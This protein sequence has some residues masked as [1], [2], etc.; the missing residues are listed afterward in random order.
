MPYLL[1][2]KRRIHGME[3]EQGACQD[4]TKDRECRSPSISSDFGLIPCVFEVRKRL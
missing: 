3:S 4:C 2:Q 1:K